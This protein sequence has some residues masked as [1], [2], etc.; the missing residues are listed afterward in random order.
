MKGC[1]SMEKYDVLIV[2]ASTTGCWFAEKM[3]KQG[4]KV[5]VIEKE[6]PDNVSRSYDIFHMGEGEMKQFDLVI[7]EEDNPIRE[8]RFESSSMF[9][10]YG[11]Y[12]VKGAPSPVIGLHKHDYIMFMAELAKKQG[13]QIVYDAS[14]SDFIYDE[15]NKIIGAKYKTEDGEKEAF[16]KI[17]AD[18]SGIPSVA[19]TKLPDSSVV[20]NFKLTPKDILYVVL[21]YVTYKEKTVNARELDGF[22]MQYKSWSAPAGKGYDSILGIGGSYSYEYAEEVFNTQFMKNAKHP[23]YTVQKVEK[24]RTPYHRSVYSFVDDSFI[25]MGDAACLTKPTCGEGCT[26]SLVQGEIAVDVI[27]KLLKEEKPLTKENM[28]SINKR[29]M[30]AQGKDFDSM[31][32]LLM[33]VVTIDF[34]EAEYLFANDVL[35]SKKILGGMDDGLNLGFKD[36][37]EIIGGIIKGIVKGKIRV[38]TV[39]NLLKGL[40]QSGDVGKLYNNYPAT[41]DGFEEWKNQADALWNS[42]GSL[43]DTCDPEILKKLGI[44]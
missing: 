8:F 10:P 11:K 12:S 31:R 26:S 20:E 28:W 40:K 2:G 9:S 13:A 16:A 1:V 37:A 7:P 36:I 6:T 32:P 25:V 35:F 19:R 38:S 34:D 39:K 3:A 4:F 14:F 43:A 22:Y 27:S 33:G 44:K 21:Y 41:F 15:N 29:Y 24:G 23:E 30:I 42:I 17:V 18:C 5:L